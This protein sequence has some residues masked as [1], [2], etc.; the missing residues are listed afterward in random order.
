MKEF[1]NNMVKNNWGDIASVIGLIITIISFIVILINV[2][3]SKRAAEQAKIAVDQVR[4][5]LLKMNTI[6]EFSS[7]LSSMDEIRRLHRQEAWAILPDRYSALKKS[8]ISIK[9]SNPNMSDEYKKVIQSAIQI[10]SSI[11]SEV[12]TALSL[13]QSPQDVAKLN[14]AISKQIDKLQQILIEIKNQIGR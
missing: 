6:A 13:K 3:R 1:I 7:A 14:Q 10:F 9:G 2:L 8:L 5:N 12:E 11:E 4:E